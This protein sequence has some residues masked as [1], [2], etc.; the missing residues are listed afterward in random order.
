MNRQLPTVLAVLA[1]CLGAAVPVFA[2]PEIARPSPDQTRER[3]AI[4]P[5]E[6]ISG[7]SADAWIGAGIA[8]TLAA[9]LHG[10]TGFDLI[11]QALV[12]DVV[13]ET[14]FEADA[15]A[16]GAGLEVG[17]RLGARWVI[18]GAYQRIG[19]QLRLTGQLVDVTTGE[20]ASSAKVDGDIDD[21]FALQDRFATELIT[22][23]RGASRSASGRKPVERTQPPVVTGSASETSP[24]PSPPAE[25]LVDSPRAAAAAAVAVRPR[26]SCSN[27]PGPA[28]PQPSGIASSQFAWSKVR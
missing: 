4:L 20:V 12:S 21:L 17:R 14:D 7:A 13:G 23:A 16:A 25:L 26:R 27:R 8:E 24:Q 22:G 11:G 18:R 28:S 3:I 5:F 9:D 19:D 15:W 6:N 2:Q 10:E 1:A